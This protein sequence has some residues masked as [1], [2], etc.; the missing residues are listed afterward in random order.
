MPV[1]P[2]VQINQSSFHLRRNTGGSQQG[3]RQ[4][5]MLV[6]IAGFVLYKN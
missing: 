3:N 2:A 1:K 4:Y 6:A 5:G